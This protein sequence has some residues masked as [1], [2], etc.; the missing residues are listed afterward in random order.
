[1]LDSGD[2]RSAVAASM[3]LPALFTPVTPRRPRADGRRPRQSAALRCAQ[4]RRRHHGRH[5]RQRRLAGPG[6]RRTA[7]R[8][9][10]PRLV[11][12]DPAALDRAREAESPAAR[13]LHRR[14]GRRVPR[15]RVSP[16]QADDD[17]GRRR[18]GAAQAPAGARAGEPDRG[19]AYPQSPP[20]PACKPC[21]AAVSPGS[22]G[23]REGVP[24]EPAHR[25][26][27]SRWR[28]AA[29]RRAG[30]RTSSCWRPSTS[31]ASSPS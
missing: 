27:A 28:W 16:L 7:H 21:N 29:A 18:Q 14:R 13:H 25:R 17:R 31:L 15:A 19:D 23:L 24:R 1:M 4:G 11:L 12:A 10:R 26:R 22:G 2:L 6:Q 3:A 5:R 30:L 8:V 9:F 20:R